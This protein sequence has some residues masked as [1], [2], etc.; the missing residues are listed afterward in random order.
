MPK[1]VVLETFKKFGLP[2]NYVPP[3]KVGGELLENLMGFV[4]S[5]PI[6]DLTNQEL[7]LYY[8]EYKTKYKPNQD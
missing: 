5:N 2:E 1:V 7:Y 4:Q 6:D 8:K 3:E